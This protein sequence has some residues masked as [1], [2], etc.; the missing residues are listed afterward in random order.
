MFLFDACSCF[1]YEKEDI[2][3]LEQDNI[4]F[5]YT[6]LGKGHSGAGVIMNDFFEFA[7]GKG[8]GKNSK[9][10]N[11]KGMNKSFPTFREWESESFPGISK[12]R[13]E[14]GKKKQKIR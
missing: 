14:N 9:I 5:Y 1:F 3:V 13:N 11:G 12:I 8:M 6:V 7:Y 4:N 10:W 2:S